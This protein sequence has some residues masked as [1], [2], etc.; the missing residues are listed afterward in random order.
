MT[1]AIVAPSPSAPTRVPPARRRPSRSTALALALAALAGCGGPGSY[2]PAE[3]LKDAA[4]L[5]PDFRVAAG[6]V[7]GVRVWNQ[8]GMSVDRA[9]VREDGRISM[10][11]L[12][13]VEVSGR[14][15]TEL[16]RQIQGRLKDFVVNP[17]VTVTIEE[18]RPLRVPVLGEVGRP[19]IYDLDREVGVLAAVAAAGG[20]TAFAHR[21]AIFVLRYRPR[22]GD[23]VPLRIRFQYAELARGAPRESGFRLKP[24]DL[25]VVE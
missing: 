12:Q 3:S 15:P 2:V 13:D 18:A 16:A 21:D 19:G 5:E 9:R 17:V 7:L 14:T 6:D 20:M 11:F 1:G 22:L 8:E 4:A 10:P 25:V 24:G 23:P